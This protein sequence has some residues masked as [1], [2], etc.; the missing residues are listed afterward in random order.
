MWTVDQVAVREGSGK[1]G[2]LLGSR[3]DELGTDHVAV[4]TALTSTRADVQPLGP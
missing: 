2:R 4:P 3:L 1:C